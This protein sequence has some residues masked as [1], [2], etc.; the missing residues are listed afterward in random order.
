MAGPCLGWE[1]ARHPPAWLPIRPFQQALGL[2]NASRRLHPQARKFTC[3]ATNSSS[4]ELIGG[5]STTSYSQMSAQLSH[6]HHAVRPLWGALSVAPPRDPGLWSMP[7]AIISH[8]AFKALMTSQIQAFP[9]A[10]PVTTAP[11]RAARWD[12]LKVHNQDAA[13]GYCFTFHAWRTGQRVLRVL[14]CVPANFA[15]LM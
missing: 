2:Q 10:K 13:R 12:D 6:G 9:H 4:S 8:P 11:S 1:P 14:G 3:T 5:L 15:K 7:P